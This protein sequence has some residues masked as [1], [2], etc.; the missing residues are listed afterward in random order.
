MPRRALDIVGPSIDPPKHAAAQTRP[1]RPTAPWAVAAPETSSTSTDPK[2]AAAA[3]NPPTS[4]LAGDDS[5]NNMHSTD[6]NN[7]RTNASIDT[8]NNQGAEPAA[9]HTRLRHDD[10][11]IT[12][13]SSCTT[14]ATTSPTPVT[15][16]P[17]GPTF[18]PTSGA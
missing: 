3:P 8:F 5:R 15:A 10:G 7:S 1:R 4:T 12:S 11:S 17:G 18:T 13:A 6:P 16:T 14:T 2:I 9:A